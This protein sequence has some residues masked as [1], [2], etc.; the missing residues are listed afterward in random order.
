MRQSCA[1]P[2]ILTLVSPR[3]DPAAQPRKY[4]F[5]WGGKGDD[6]DMKD[7]EMF[8]DWMTALDRR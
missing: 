6:D 8:D 3:L 4:R 1:R 7:V 2:S 5:L